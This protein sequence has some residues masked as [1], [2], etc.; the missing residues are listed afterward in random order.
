MKCIRA[1]RM[2]PEK[3]VV[4]VVRRSDVAAT[5]DPWTLT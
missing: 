1:A 4:L 5:G 3:F 2:P